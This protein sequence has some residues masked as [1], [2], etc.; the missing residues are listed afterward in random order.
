M[1]RDEVTNETFRVDHLLSE[2][3]TKRLKKNKNSLELNDLIK[4]LENSELNDLNEIDSVIEK[5]KIKAPNT[6]N[7]LSPVKE[8]NLMFQTQMG[9]TGQ[10]KRFK[11]IFKIDPFF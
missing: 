4:K 7:K 5:F 6:G 10:I 9:S 3:L 11:T 2:Q 8:F 1:V